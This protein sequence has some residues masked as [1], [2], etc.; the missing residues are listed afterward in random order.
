MEKDKIVEEIAQVDYS[1]I[2]MPMYAVYW[3]ALEYPGKCVARLFNI[4]KPTSVV[5]IKDSVEEMQEYFDKRTPFYFFERGAGDI[6]ELL[7]VWL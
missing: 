6:K 4:D 2:D 5:I 3:D 7:G 1:A